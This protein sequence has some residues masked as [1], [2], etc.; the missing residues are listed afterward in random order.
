MNAKS[1]FRTQI[2]I[3]SAGIRQHRSKSITRSGPDLRET[4]EDR[5]AHQQSAD[6]DRL[7]EGL[8]NILNVLKFHFTQK[9]WAEIH[10][11]RRRRFLYGDAERAVFK[12]KSREW[13]L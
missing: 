11:S 8:M 13:H 9:L 4:S 3:I 6:A 10:L 7:C 12:T 5:C 2:S 1:D